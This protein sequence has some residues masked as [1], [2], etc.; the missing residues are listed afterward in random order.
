[1]REQ[2]GFTLVELTIALAIAVVLTGIVIVRVDGWSSKTTLRASARALGNLIRTYR[3]KAQLEESAYALSI[4]LEKG[5]YCVQA[6]DEDVP[7]GSLEVVRKGKL[8]TRRSFGT[9]IVDG[10]EEKKALTLF[11]DDRG[12]L[13]EIQI[14][15][16]NEDGDTITLVLGTLVNEVGYA[17]KK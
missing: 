16:R 2:R 10:L 1:M 5:T 9:V 13:P 14:P 4:D 15:I 11:L 12:I 6:V 8:G 3:E 17:E 7:L